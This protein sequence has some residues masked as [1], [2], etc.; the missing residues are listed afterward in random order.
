[1]T[2]DI[3]KQYRTRDGR[4][5]RILY[6]DGTDSERPV[7]GFIGACPATYHWPIDGRFCPSVT[8]CGEDL[9][10]IRPKRT[11]DVWVNVYPDRCGGGHETRAVADQHA[12]SGRIACLHITRE[13]EEGEG[14]DAL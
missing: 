4:K 7:V 3:T 6:T 8:D 9:I 2:I 13:Y 5:V 12:S 10:E 11:L 14:L 1:M